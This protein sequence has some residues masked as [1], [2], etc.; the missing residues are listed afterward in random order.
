MKRYLYI[1]LFLITS[2]CTK[3]QN[4]LGFGNLIPPT[5]YVE[6]LYVNPAGNKLYIG[7]IFQ[8]TLN[9]KTFR[10]IMVYDGLT[11]DTLGTGVTTGLR[12]TDIV[13]YKNNMYICGLIGYFGTKLIKG[14]AKWNGTKWDSLG[15]QINGGGG[16]LTFKIFNNE[17]YMGGQF[18]GIG[19]LN[20][21]TIVKY[22][23]TNW[24][25]VGTTPFPYI[26]VSTTV[27]INS[28][29]VYNNELYV[30]GTFYDSLGN[31]ICIAKFDGTNWKT[32]GVTMYGGFS[33][34]TTLKVYNNKLY[35]A[36]RFKEIEGNVGNAIM[37]FDGTTWTNVGKAITDAGA[38]I[39]RNMQVINNKLWVVG[40]F[41]SVEDTL[42]AGGIAYWNDTVWCV[43]PTGPEIYNSTSLAHFQNKIFMGGSFNLIGGDT[44]NNL[45]IL[46][47]NATTCT[48]NPYHTTQNNIPFNVFPN[49]FTNDITIQIP[50]DYTLNDTKISIT[51]TLG[52]LLLTIHPTNYNKIINTASLASGMYYLTLSDNANKKS[53]KIIKE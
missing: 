6:S 45:V 18:S 53:T 44:L 43:P 37:R 41:K 50:T 51:N 31:H 14:V 28:M 30:G 15:V 32:V 21:N 8:S 46:N 34:I 39:I 17:L 48:R 4:W 24:L 25:P 13:E 1:I 12:V 23:G 11:F 5:G 27:N 35:V 52:Q 19:S 29:E 49:P 47:T 9:G 33:Y 40:G 3:G 36:G 20:E 2:F 7:G 22:D 42:D 16:I 10:N 38:C 26:Y